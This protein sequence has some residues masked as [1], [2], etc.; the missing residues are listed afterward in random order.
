[1]DAKQALLGAM[2]RREPTLFDEVVEEFTVDPEQAPHMD[3]HRAFGE[4][5][6]SRHVLQRFSLLQRVSSPFGKRP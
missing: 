1:M 2:P 5:L 3:R 4:I 6:R